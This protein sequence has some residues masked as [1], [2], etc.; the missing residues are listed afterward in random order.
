MTLE[1]IYY[2]G[3]TIAVVAILASLAAIWFQ[4]RQQHRLAKLEITRA[5]WADAI[6]MLRSQAEDEEK[7]DFLQ[8]AL[9]TNEPLSDAEKTRLYLVL[10]SLFV[11]MENGYAMAQS[12]MMEEKFWPRMRASIVDYLKPERGRRWWAIARVRTF[13]ANDAF[14]AEVDGI[15]EEINAAKQAV[16]QKGAG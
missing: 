12:G 5:V 14:V 16:K 7:A 4:M 1:N 15:V 3:Q 11:G 8:R 10:S 9:F 2:I 6:E 13:A